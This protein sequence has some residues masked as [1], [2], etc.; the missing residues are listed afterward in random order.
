VA[1]VGNTTPAPTS[2]THNRGGFQYSGKTHTVLVSQTTVEE[3]ATTE[4]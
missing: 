3:A 1:F 2:L 4:G